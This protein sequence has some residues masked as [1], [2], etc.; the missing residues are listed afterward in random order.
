MSSVAYY[1]FI[2]MYWMMQL[3]HYSKESGHT[4]N[5]DSNPEC[6]ES[7]DKD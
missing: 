1:I 5:I 6:F 3:I 2:E 4:D 7:N